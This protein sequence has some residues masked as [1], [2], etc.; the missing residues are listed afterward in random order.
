MVNRLLVGALV[1]SLAALVSC[2]DPDPPSGLYVAG[3]DSQATLAFD[4]KG[5]V[6]VSINYCEGY[7][8]DDVTFEQD[9][10]KIILDS[11]NNP[12]G[13]PVV[14]E[15]TEPNVLTLESEGWNFTCGN[16]KVGDTWTQSE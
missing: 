15:I 12:A 16:C 5:V 6:A 1:A 3:C 4:T 2:S 9:G 7:A 13:D 11:P 14:F 8:T 10:D